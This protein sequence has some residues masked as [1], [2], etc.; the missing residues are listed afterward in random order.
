MNKNRFYMSGRSATKQFYCI[1][2]EPVSICLYT[3]EVEL[4]KGL[5]MY[6]EITYCYTDE[7]RSHETTQKLVKLKATSILLEATEIIFYKIEFPLL[8][9]DWVQSSPTQSPATEASSKKNLLNCP[10]W[11]SWSEACPCGRDRPSSLPR[12]ALGRFL[13]ILMSLLSL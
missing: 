11:S 10:R 5:R 9:M 2:I 12:E 4:L 7:Q 6:L 3:W 8:E 13:S 1:T